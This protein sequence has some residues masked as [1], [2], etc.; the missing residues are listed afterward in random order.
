MRFYVSEPVLSEQM[1]VTDPSVST[2]GR[3]RISA[4]KETILRAPSASSTV[5]TAG[6]LAAPWFSTDGVCLR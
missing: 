3:R 2:V 6:S 4:L 1:V 5:T